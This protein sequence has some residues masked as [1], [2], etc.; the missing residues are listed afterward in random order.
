MRAITQRIGAHVKLCSIGHASD[1]ALAVLNSGG[2]FR[3]TRAPRGAG[4]T[5]PLFSGSDKLAKIRPAIQNKAPAGETL[6]VDKCGLI[7]CPSLS[8]GGIAS[9]G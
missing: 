7:S 5:L 4:T 3:L 2:A 6:V 8:A 1:R 9:W